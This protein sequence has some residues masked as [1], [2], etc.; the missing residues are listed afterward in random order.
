MIPPGKTLLDEAT[1]RFLAD[2][3]TAALASKPAA[4]VLLGAILGMAAMSWWQTKGIGSAREPRKQR[5]GWPGGA[6]Y[7]SR[8]APVVSRSG[9]RRDQPE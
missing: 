1:A 7:R 6:R 2:L 9:A 8:P 4:A 3:V 5:R